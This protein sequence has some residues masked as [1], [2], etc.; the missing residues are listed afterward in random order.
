M[1]EATFIK[2]PKISRTYLSPTSLMRFQTFTWSIDSWAKSGISCF[3][4]ACM[5]SHCASWFQHKSKGIIGISWWWLG[6]CTAQWNFLFIFQKKHNSLNFLFRCT[7]TRNNAWIQTGCCCDFRR[8]Q[9]WH[10]WIQ[11]KPK[12]FKPTKSFNSS[13]TCTTKSW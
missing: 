6:T 4:L 5:H 7:L 13:L 11:T 10:P 12:S 3:H 1:E 9:Q 8:R 2:K